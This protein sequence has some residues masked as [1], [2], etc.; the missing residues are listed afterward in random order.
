MIIKD[1]KL[2][3]T[4]DDMTRALNYG[5]DSVLKDGFEVTAIRC[6]PAM[7]KPFEIFFAGPI[8]TRGSKK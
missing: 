2:C 6:N 8:E 5:L 7:V 1:G 4:A 3:L